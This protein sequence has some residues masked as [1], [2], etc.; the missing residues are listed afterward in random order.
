MGG[1]EEGGSNEVLSRSEF[2]ASVLSPP[3]GQVEGS[4]SPPP[5]LPPPSTP[6]PVHFSLPTGH[7]GAH[8]HNQK[9]RKKC[10]KHNSTHVPVPRTRA[11]PPPMGHHQPTHGPPSPLP[12]VHTV[13]PTDP[14]TLPPPSQHT[15]LR[16]LHPHGC[17]TV[18]SP[19]PHRGFLGGASNF[20]SPL[21]QRGNAGR[22]PRRRPRRRPDM[23]QADGPQRHDLAAVHGIPSHGAGRPPDLLSPCWTPLPGVTSLTSTTP[24]DT[25][26]GYA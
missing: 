15:L 1:G 14:T 23:G 26:G 9:Q 11:P 5:P 3:G 12:P 10:K 24:E 6:C 4:T 22:G 2:S 18:P 13:P 16:A 20:G 21:R 8:H 7:H 25:N 19:L 17:P